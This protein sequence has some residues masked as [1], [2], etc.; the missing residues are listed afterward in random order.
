[1][2]ENGQEKIVAFDT[3]FTTNQ[4]QILKILLTYIEPA[5]QKLIAVYIK[6]LELQYTLSFFQKYPASTLSFT[7]NVPKEDAFNLSKL[8]EEILPFCSPSDREQLNQL[9]N[10]YR[11]FENMQ[12]MMQM[13]QM[14]K[15]LFPEGENSMDG[16]PGS[17][18][19]A[20][21]GLSDMFNSQ[22]NSPG[23][24]ISQLFDMFGNRNP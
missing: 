6:F 22:E 18:F 14:M 20:F 8:C 13:I 2:A 10:L 12:E 9:R 23:I 15:D 24:D 11:N 7:E 16:D 5:Q 1:M 3:L 4:I 19:S 17:V 21:S